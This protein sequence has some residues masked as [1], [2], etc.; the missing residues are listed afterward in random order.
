MDRLFDLIHDH[1]A[2]ERELVKAVARIEEKLSELESQ[3]NLLRT[4]HS[5]AQAQRAMHKLE[6]D[7]CYAVDDVLER[8]EM[9]ILET[10]YAN[11]TQPNVDSFESEFQEQENIDELKAQ[12]DEQKNE[13][14]DNG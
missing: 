6:A 2:R 12:L 11:P 1:E 8:W 9:R 10:E 7:P 13:E 3:R 5:T 14:Q 4:R